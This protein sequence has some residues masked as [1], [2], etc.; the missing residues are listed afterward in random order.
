MIALIILGIACTVIGYLLNARQIRRD[1][2]AIDELIA[3][4]QGTAKPGHDRHL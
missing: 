1:D 3:T 4:A 2:E